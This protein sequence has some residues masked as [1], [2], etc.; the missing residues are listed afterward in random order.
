VNILYGVVG[1]GMGHATRSKVVITHLQARG[2]KVKIVVSG[3]AHAFLRRSFADV[4]E[5]AGLTMIY[6]Q[7]AVKRGRTVLNFLKE[8]PLWGGWAENFETMTRI[9]QAFDAD[10]V[11]SDFESFAY[12]YGMQHEL[13]VISIDNMQ[14]LARCELDV[15]I[16][17]EHRVDYRIAQGIVRAKLP[18]C[19]HYLITSFFFPKV[20]KARTSLYPPLLRDDILAA[21]ARASRGEHLLVYQTS[22]SYAELLPV[23]ERLDVPC[24]VY[25]LGRDE[26]RGQLE[27]KSFSEA[28]F[29]EDLA[30]CRGVIA[31]GGFSLLS[32][33][34][35]LGKPILSVP[36]RKQFE[37]LLN[38]LYVQKLG[39]G[40][41][42]EHLTERD[43]AAFLEREPDYAR[44]VGAF[45]QDGNRE[46][47]GAVDRLLAGVE[48]GERVDAD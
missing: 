35:Y 28:G 23:L 16:P 42:A 38:A 39:Y 20:R 15:D 3:R 26:Q 12:L 27:L 34:V 21:K 17:E 37:Q 4:E 13:P 14:V 31:G 36:I 6:E 9:R 25:G 11:I 47:L 1:E 2:H 41:Y 10:C 45:R 19:L 44:A 22:D 8:L 33:A 24:K 48:R 29:V 46:L 7:N 5:I 30:T 18:G 43:I 32:E 40:T